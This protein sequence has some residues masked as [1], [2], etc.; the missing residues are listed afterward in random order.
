MSEPAGESN[1]T[2]LAGRYR[3]MRR[4]SFLG[5]RKTDRRFRWILALYL[6]VT[7]VIISYTA[8]A[9]ADQRGSALII[10][11]AARQRALAERYVKDVVLVTDGI[12]ADPLDDAEQ[13]LTNASALLVGGDVIAVHGADTEIVIPTASEDLAVIAKLEQEQNLIERLTALGHDVMQL[14]PADPMFDDKLL[15]CVSRVLS[16]PACR[17]M[18]SGR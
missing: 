17:T 11:I 9:I 6:I 18:P 12:Q 4:T 5:E 8:G 2:P 10:N 1:R 14:D 3:A 16:S 13:L 15:E 7:A